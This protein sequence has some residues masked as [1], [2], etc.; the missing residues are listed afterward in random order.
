[1]GS[2]TIIARCQECGGSRNCEV[3]GRSR[4]KH[5]A[6]STREDWY[7]LSCRGCDYLFLQI[8]GT[9]FRDQG[10][11]EVA[12]E[13]ITT[14]PAPPLIPR[15]PYRV[16]PHFIKA[17]SGPLSDT[18]ELERYLRELYRAINDELNVLAL[19]CIRTCLSITAELVGADPTTSVGERATYLSRA[20]FMTDEDAE[21]FRR[22]CR[23]GEA[24]DD[25]RYRPETA[26]VVEVT[27]I[28]EEVINKSLVQ[29][30]RAYKGKELQSLRR[31]EAAR[32]KTLERTGTWEKPVRPWAITQANR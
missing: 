31:T 10:E 18:Y 2:T 23:I 16:M 21:I 17:V 19:L 14:W 25:P 5:A 4:N 3:V 15:E 24:R 26:D 30:W 32:L 20:G 22:V 6:P 12:E 29:P 8:A 27:K 11:C 7:L 13:W 9:V 28:M 1:M